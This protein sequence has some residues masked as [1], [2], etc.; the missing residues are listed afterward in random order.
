MVFL[1]TISSSEE[2]SVVVTNSLDL[3]CGLAEGTTLAAGR[4]EGTLAE[5]GLIEGG[6]VSDNFCFLVKMIKSTKS[7]LRNFEGVLSLNF[8]NP[9][10]RFWYFEK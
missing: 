8:F 4:I 9:K 10:P 6:G 7:F 5:G 1:T 2:E 3:Y